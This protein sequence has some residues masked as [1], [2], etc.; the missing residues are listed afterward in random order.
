MAIKK[1][2]IIPEGTNDYGDVLHPETSVDMVV[3]LERHGIAS[4]TNTYTVS[5]PNTPKLITGLKISVKFTNANT[6]TS[7]LNLNGLGAKSIIKP[8]GGRP[9]IKAD[10]VYILVY[11]GV[12]FQLLGEGGEYGTADPSD[13]IKGKTIGTEEGLKTGTLE[14]TGTSLVGNVLS[15]K[16]FYSTSPKSKLTGTMPNRGAVSKT[17]TTQG[18]SYTIPEGY[19]SGSGKVKA[20]FANLVAS[21]IKKGVNIGGV[22]GS[23]EGEVKYETG[24][25]GESNRN[26]SGR[27]VVRFS[28]S[29]RNP[30]VL[31]IISASNTI[32]AYDFVNDIGVYYNYSQDR[33]E[34]LYVD[35]NGYSIEVGCDVSPSGTYHVWGN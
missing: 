19:H 10:G 12:N 7:S 29:M 8:G 23:Y 1:I 34:D 21:N 3:D 28:I 30:K 17:I 24:S 5:I 26:D 31:L 27:A 25:T 13:V 15:G 22:N 2:Q 20:Q 4:G 9:N 6:G 35:F 18:G 14:L 32:R 11:D 16:T 33:H